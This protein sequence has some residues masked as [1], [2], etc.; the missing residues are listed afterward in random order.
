VALYLTVTG[1]LGVAFG[2]IIRNTAGGIAALFGLL[3]VLPGLSNLLPTSWQSSVVPYFPSSAGQALNTQHGDRAR[4]T[5]GPGSRSS[6][7]T[8]S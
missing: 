3:L 1:L 7:V 8:W 2:F 4:C 5:R 6:S